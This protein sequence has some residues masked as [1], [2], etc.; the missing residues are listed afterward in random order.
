MFETEIARE[1]QG[2]CCFEAFGGTVAAAGCT[3][4]NLAIFDTRSGLVIHH[5]RLHGDD[6]RAMVLMPSTTPAPS[7]SI[8]TTSFDGTAGIWSLKP[9]STNKPC[10]ESI[11]M[12][13]GLHTDKVLSVTYDQSARSIFTTG[14]DGRVVTWQKH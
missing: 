3:G 14:A 9:S 4:G 8:V 2:I 11:A 6:I 5:E 12:L 13:S 7:P 10:F 1:H